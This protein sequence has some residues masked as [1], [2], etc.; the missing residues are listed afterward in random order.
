M[1]HPIRPRVL[2]TFAVETEARYFKRLCPRSKN[3]EVLITGMGAN[4]TSQALTT[5]DPSRYGLILSS[6]FA[7]AVSP[8]L[9]LQ[10]LVYASEQDVLPTE[11]LN[12]LGCKQVKMGHSDR[13]L[14]TVD[15][16]KAFHSH[17]GCEVV[18]M[19]SSIICAWARSHG[20]PSLTIRIITDDANED[21]P[22]DFN[23]VLRKNGSQ[24]PWKL[25]RE[26]G[27]HP[28]SIPRLISFG[29]RIEKASRNLAHCLQEILGLIHSNHERSK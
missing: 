15:E 25:L 28:T 27:I 21:L 7:G 16:K 11:K 23:R 14:I 6:G 12:K 24:S 17:T 8:S 5:L 2:V 20:L 3:L 19:E 4:Q 26:I 1:G 18:E 22:L 9:S 13:I 10:D 29:S